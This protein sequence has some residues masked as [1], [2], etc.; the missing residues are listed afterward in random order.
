M[1]CATI[2]GL[3]TFS[4]LELIRDL[5]E[6][7]LSPAMVLPTTA[8]VISPSLPGNPFRHFEHHESRICESS[9]PPRVK[10]LPNSAINS[11]VQT[12]E[13]LPTLLASRVL[14]RPG[15]H[16]GFREENDVKALGSVLRESDVK[17]WWG[18]YGL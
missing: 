17:R 8:F 12:K 9:S 16:G 18:N 7:P 2:C 11:A 3:W 4:S 10:R 5:D 15:F 14:L 13:P 6:T 1:F